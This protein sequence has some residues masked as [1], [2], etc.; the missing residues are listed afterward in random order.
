MKPDVEDVIQHVIDIL[1]EQFPSNL[2]AVDARKA[3][4]LNPEPPVD[5]IFG[6]KENLP[7]MPCIVVT[8]HE[9][10]VL[11]DEH[12]WRRQQY[13]IQVDAYYQADDVENVSRIVRRYGAAL[14]D[15]LTS[16]SSAPGY[17][18][19]IANISQQYWDTMSS[20]NGGLF[21]GVTVIFDAIVATD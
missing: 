9:T 12:G 17:W 5:W 21:Q 10:T 8:G 11:E 14:D 13:K 16:N 3:N 1:Q 15:T 2:A 7:N 18:S 19:D 20:K 4:P 6:D